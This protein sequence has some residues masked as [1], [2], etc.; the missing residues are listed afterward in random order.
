MLVT[1]KAI[2]S[3]LHNS[4]ARAHGQPEYQRRPVQANLR[5]SQ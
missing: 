3:D 4:G 2:G 5:S 1:L